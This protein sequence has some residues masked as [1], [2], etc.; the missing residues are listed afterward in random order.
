MTERMNLLPGRPPFRSESDPS[1][2]ADLRPS[3]RIGRND[4]DCKG[5]DRMTI[6]LTSDPLLHPLLSVPM[7][8]IGRYTPPAS[9]NTYV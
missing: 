6:Q 4:R 1:Q 7:Q 3:F 5:R 2:S 8:G 9:A